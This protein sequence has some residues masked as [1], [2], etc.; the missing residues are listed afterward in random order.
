MVIKMKCLTRKV[1]IDK[2]GI[3]TIPEEIRKKLKIKEFDILEIMATD[4][5]IVIEKFEGDLD[6]TESL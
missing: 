2:N 1:A 5:I 4:N 3:I 6:E